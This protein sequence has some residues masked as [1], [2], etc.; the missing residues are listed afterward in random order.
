MNELEPIVHDKAHD[1]SP[2]TRLWAR[3][4]TPLIAVVALLG[5]VFL[6]AA[7]SLMMRRIYLVWRAVRWKLRRRAERKRGGASGPQYASDDEE[8]PSWKED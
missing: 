5:I 7:V 1:D 6:I 2:V 4:P 3:P 8:A